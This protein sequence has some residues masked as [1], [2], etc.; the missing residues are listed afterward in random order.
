MNMNTR[1]RFWRKAVASVLIYSLIF[2]QTVQSA[3]AASTDIS[4]VPMAVKNQVAPNIMFT[5]DDSG[6]MQF[7]VVPENS[8]VYF[9]S[10]PDPLYGAAWYGATSA[11]SPD[12]TGQTNMPVITAR[13]IQPL[14]LRPG[15]RYVPWTNADK[16]LMS[17]HGHSSG[18]THTTR[19]RVR[20]I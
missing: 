2:G 19:V 17:N 6:S 18:T 16:T 1:Q 20:A 12:L 10:P 13:Q 11:M 9:V 8:N 14:V 3:Q 7:E 5:L 15:K 4:D